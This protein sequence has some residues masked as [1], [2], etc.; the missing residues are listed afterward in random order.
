LDDVEPL[1]FL[2]EPEVRLELSREIVSL[3]EIS[4]PEEEELKEI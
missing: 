4:E 3:S 1:K 2:E